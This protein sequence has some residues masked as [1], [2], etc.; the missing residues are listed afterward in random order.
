MLEYY[1]IL[2]YILSVYG[3]Y[4]LKLARLIE[5]YTRASSDHILL[6]IRLCVYKKTNISI[7]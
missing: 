5:N 7:V 4:Y 2:S 3:H 1:L 6:I